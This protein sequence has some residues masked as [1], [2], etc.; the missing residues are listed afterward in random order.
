[1][2]LGPNLCI[3]APMSIKKS[4]LISRRTILSGGFCALTVGC[5][6][7]PL[8]V[9]AVK[10]IKTVVVGDSAPDFNREQISKIPYAT[11]SAKIGRG[12]KSLLV[13]GKVEHQNLHW[14]SSDNA[15][16]VTA[17]GRVVQ[18]AGFPVN[19]IKTRFHGRDPVNRQLHLSHLQKR[20]VREIDS[21]AKMR[22]SIPVFSE[23]ERIG[24][25]K[26][27]IAGVEIETVLVRE[28][29]STKTVNW[30]FTNYFWADIYDGFIWKSR[31]HIARSFPPIDIEV[32]KPSG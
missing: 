6:E 24:E 30:S 10:A 17:N 31:Q 4:T 3:I 26:I 23:F 22:F 18:T 16:L 11:I 5:A 12:P 9:N 29:N 7:V 2:Y 8:V 21:D 20:T 25:R 32:L 27:K 1:M 28:T 14:I 19:L 15:V 13:L